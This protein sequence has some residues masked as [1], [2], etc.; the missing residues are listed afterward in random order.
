MAAGARDRVLAM[1]ENANGGWQATVAGRTLR[2]VVVDGWQQGWLLPA[3]AAGTVTVSF[4]PDEPYRAG[5]FGGAGLL[6]LVLLAAVIPA[7][8]RQAPA[9]SPA[10]A[11]RSDA[12]LGSPGRMLRPVLATA[13]GLVALISVGGLATVGVALV[14][15]GAM[16][17]YRALLAQLDG[18]DQRQTRRAQRLMWRWLPVVLFGVAARLV[19]AGRRAARRGRPSAGRRWP[20]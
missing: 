12:A 11:E 5:L 7:A 14:G 19:A 18:V 9:V 2:P 10:I 17:V 4:A 13:I 8:R 16:V 20:W 3:G 15:L 6:L 1:R